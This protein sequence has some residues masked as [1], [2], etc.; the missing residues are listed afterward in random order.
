MKKFKIRCIG[1]KDCIFK[2]LVLEKGYEMHDEGNIH[3]VKAENISE[4]LKL[5]N[6]KLDLYNR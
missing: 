6:D 2:Q 3:I 4:L 5:S 1:V